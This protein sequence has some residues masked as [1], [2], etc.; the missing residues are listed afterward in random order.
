MVTTPGH[1][2]WILHCPA[3]SRDFLLLPL[4]YYNL[5]PTEQPVDQVTLFVRRIL[6]FPHGFRTFWRSSPSPPNSLHGPAPLVPSQKTVTQQVASPLTSCSGWEGPSVWDSG[7]HWAEGDTAHCS[8]TFCHEHKL[9]PH[10]GNW[11]GAERSGS[12]LS[13]Y[14]SDLPWIYLL[15]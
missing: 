14:T 15:V 9:C 4:L 5:F 6:R 12:F 3:F 8:C 10:S 2:T 1:F 13:C 7:C 11:G